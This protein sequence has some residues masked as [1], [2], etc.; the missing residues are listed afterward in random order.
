MER[1]RRDHRPEE[2]GVDDAVEYMD[3]YN[4]A[5]EVNVL[6]VVLSTS[7]LNSSSRFTVRLRL[8]HPSPPF[9]SN[10][11]FTASLQS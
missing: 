11:N 2:V 6:L 7:P 1:D 3:T 4:D 5:R 8:L 10:T 9:Y